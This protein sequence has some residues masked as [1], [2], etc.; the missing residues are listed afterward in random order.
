[1]MATVVV[2]ESLH[3]HYPLPDVDDPV[4]RPFWDGTRALKFLQQRDL[5]TGE[6][7]W[8]P[9]PMYWKG[10]QRLEWFEASGKG[11]VYTYVVGSEPFLPAFKHLLPH[12]MVVVELAERAVDRDAGR[13][14]GSHQLGLAREA[15]PGAIFPGSDGF[16]QRIEDVA[17]L[18]G[19]GGSPNLSGKPRGAR[20]TPWPPLP[21]STSPEP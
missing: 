1:M 7:H 21:R 12:I 13:A 2:E 15:L 10:G 17:V 5:V 8:P 20:P 4:M 3:P 11:A 19:A 9:K 14:E 6:I 16:A 18:R